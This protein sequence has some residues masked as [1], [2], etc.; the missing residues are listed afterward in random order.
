MDDLTCGGDTNHGSCNVSAWTTHL[1]GLNAAEC[2]FWDAS[3]GCIWLVDMLAPSLIRVQPETGKSRVWPMPE[4]IGSFAL[5]EGGDL[6]ILALRSGLFLFDL[7]S[8]RMVPLANP[9]ADR[10]ENRLNDGKASPEGRFWVGSMNE[11]APRRPQGALYRVD[12]DG[13]VTRMLDG[14]YTSNGLAWS[15]DG[16][17]MYHSDSRAQILQ[18]FDYDPVTG[19]LSGAEVLAR[20]S[21]TDGRPDGGTVDS[22]GFYWSAGASAGCLNRF[23]P[24]GSLDKKQVLPVKAPSMLCYGGA[25]LRRVFVTSLSAVRDGISEKGKLISFG[26][27]VQGLAG[28]RF[29]PSLSLMQRSGER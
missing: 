25:D 22:E 18:A 24:N 14:L 17:R 4:T 7:V 8:A 1:E 5:C 2:P 28:H 16:R 29:K 21:E 15:A 6:V 13:R 20:P 26:S 27:D 23:A 3:S 11:S 19:D 12:F 10:P 9:E